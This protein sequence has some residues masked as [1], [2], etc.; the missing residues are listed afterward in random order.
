MLADFQESLNIVTDFQYT[1]RVVLHTETAKLIQDDFKMTSLFI[2]LQQMI[3]NKSYPLY[4][5]HIRS[6]TGLP[7][8][9][10]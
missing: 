9:L 5:T 4:I 7:G 10:I 2:Q 8:P 3:R 1:E 6:H